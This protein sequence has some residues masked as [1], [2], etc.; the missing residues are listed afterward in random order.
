MSEDFQLI[1]AP[2]GVLHPYDLLTT[3]RQKVLEPY[4]TEPHVVSPTA[5]YCLA[6]MLTIEAPDIEEAYTWFNRVVSKTFKSKL[7]V[8]KSRNVAISALDK[9]DDSVRAEIPEYI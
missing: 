9:L 5:P 8:V 6:V 3:L 1:D 7:A 4:I 2:Y